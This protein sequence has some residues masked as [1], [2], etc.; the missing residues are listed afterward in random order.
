MVV[1]GTV[2]N[3]RG[4]APHIGW[5]VGEEAVQ[6]KWWWHASNHLVTKSDGFELYSYREYKLPHVMY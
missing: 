6:R 2:V 3:G 5:M 1:L 4:G